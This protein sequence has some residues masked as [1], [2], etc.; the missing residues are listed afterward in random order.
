MTTY[1]LTWNRDERSPWHDLRKN[2]A[3]LKK[4][5]SWIGRWSTGNTKKIKPGDRVF[6]IKLG[7][8]KPHGIIASGSAVSDVYD[9]LHWNEEQRAKGIRALYIKVRFDTLLDPEK[10]IFPR[11]RLDNGIYT[12]MKWEP[13]ASGWTIPDDVAAKLEKDWAAFLKSSIS[14]WSE[15][16]D[17]VTSVTTVLSKAHRGGAIFG[18]PETNRKVERAAITFVTNYYESRG[19]KVESI[20]ADNRGFDLLCVKG[21]I[22]KHVEV[23][24]IQGKI[25]SFI[26]TK[27]E[28]HLAK[29]DKRFILCVVMEAIS[30][31]PQLTQYSAE[32]FIQ[33]FDLTPLSFWARLRGARRILRA[34][35]T[36]G[37][38]G[39]VNA[40]C[41]ICNGTGEGL[42]N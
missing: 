26:I 11:A 24:G 16:S 6:I 27:S 12:K 42:P 15:S 5:G 9:D 13:P 21:S 1:L 29:T 10:D 7:K 2:I 35:F 20:E 8:Q 32:A 41:P 28:V 36:C 22:E 31:Q 17:S 3:D 33:R 34:C 14:S 23:K 38:S 39:K 25:E 19:W 18:P 40:T 37:G 4:K 30:K